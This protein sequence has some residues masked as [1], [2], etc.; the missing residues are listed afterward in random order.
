[1][2]LLYI[3][4]VVLAF[5]I[6]WGTVAVTMRKRKWPALGS[7]LTG[8]GTAMIA[9]IAVVIVLMIAAPEDPVVADLRRTPKQPEAENMQPPSKRYVSA[10][11]KELFDDYHANEVAADLKYKGKDVLVVGTVQAI[12]KDILNNVIV[13][14]KTSNQFQPVNVSLKRRYEISAS[15]FKKGDV[16]T[17]DCKGEGM[18]IGSPSLKECDLFDLQ[19]GKPAV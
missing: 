6:V 7:H 9:A 2:E 8:I 11:A 18:I 15:R 13:R 1:M 14:L 4:V 16:L 17:F 5:V 19:T 12:E 3:S 10:A